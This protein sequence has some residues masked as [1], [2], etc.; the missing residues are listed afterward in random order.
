MMS[1]KRMENGKKT[2]E[3]TENQRQHQ[4][5]MQE[6]RSLLIPRKLQTQRHSLKIMLRI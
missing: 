1:C 5:K 2:P 6:Q 3:N 4:K